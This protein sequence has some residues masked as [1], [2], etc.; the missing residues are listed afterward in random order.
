MSTEAMVNRELV[1][2]RDGYPN[3]FTESPDEWM[4]R[5]K[6]YHSKLRRFDIETVTVACERA[7]ERHPDRFPTVGQLAAI[8]RVVSAEHDKLAKRAAEERRRE[9][10]ARNI[11]QYVAD[12]RRHVIPD[13]VAEQERWINEATS[14]FEQL[15]R[16]WECESMNRNLDPNRPSPRDVGERR[17][18]ELM[19]LLAEQGVCRVDSKPEPGAFG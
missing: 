4:G 7:P 10:E 2:L 15:S 16:R 13:G 11:A 6:A 3:L 5:V 17:I 12:R 14:P 1:S 19:H 9:E 8:C 18:S